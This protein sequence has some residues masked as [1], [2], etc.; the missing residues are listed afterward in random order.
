MK[1]KHKVIKE[2]QYLSPDKKIFILKIGTILE[3]Y[4]TKPRTINTDFNN[5]NKFIKSNIINEIIDY[6]DTRI[7][8]S[9]FANT[10]SKT[11]I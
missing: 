3:E 8:A 11:Y 7:R 4:M 9:S 6:N 1:I 10:I 5:F 2:F